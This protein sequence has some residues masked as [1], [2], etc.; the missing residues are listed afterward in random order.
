[1]SNYK[2]YNKGDRVTVLNGDSIEGEAELIK[3]IKNIYNDYPAWMVLFD[4]EDEEPVARTIY[5]T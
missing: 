2:I 3:E 1:M 5:P 4:G